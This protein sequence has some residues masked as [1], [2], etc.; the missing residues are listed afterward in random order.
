ML[1]LNST[2]LERA[3]PANARRRTW[4]HPELVSHS[5]L[6]LTYDRLYLAPLA[7]TPKPEVLAAIDSGAD[8]DVVLGPL[9]TVIDVVSMRQLK[10]DLLSNSLNVEYAGSRVGRAKLRITF[11]TPEAADACFTKIWRRVGDG[12]QLAP[13]QRDT[14]H[15]IRGPLGLLG[16][17]LFITAATAG[18]LSI[19]E[20]AATARPLHSNPT[21]TG[22]L[23]AIVSSATK[24]A[25]DSLLDGLNWKLV[26]GL[27]GIGAALSQI[28]MY[29]RLTTP[30]ISLELVRT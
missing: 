7:G 9:T 17:V 8:L 30:P 27:G 10:L 13:Y 21:S 24:S 11:T 4:S 15:S 22:E 23:P 2:P 16:L 28:W 18:L 29:R 6:V 5:V 12:F 20:D 1:G 19:R 14:W 26:C 3:L 25:N